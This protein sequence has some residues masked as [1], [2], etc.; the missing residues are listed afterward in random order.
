M[1]EHEI[2]PA[3]DQRGEAVL[4]VV[5]ERAVGRLDE[6]V[7]ARPPERR[8]SQLVVAQGLG[9]VEVDLATRQHADPDAPLAQGVLDLA[10]PAGDLPGPH[11]GVVGAHVGRGHER[12][13]AAVRRHLG[14]G[15]AAAEVPR[16][17]V[18]AREHVRVEV[19]HRDA[20]RAGPRGKRRTLGARSGIM[21]QRW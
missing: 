18:H 6:E 21:D 12:A 15:H 7:A 16:A 20:G 3:G 11:A 14:H 1:G 17:I 8:E 9:G 13:G 19:D 10:R 2:E 4:V 5:G